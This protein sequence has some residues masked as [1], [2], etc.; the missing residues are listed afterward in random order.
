MVLKLAIL[1]LVLLTYVSPASK[2]YTGELIS[3]GGNPGVSDLTPNISIT[4]NITLYDSSI[5]LVLSAYQRTINTTAKQT[6]IALTA[7][8]NVNSTNRCIAFGFSIRSEYR[9]KNKYIPESG[10]GGCDAFW[11]SECS[12]GVINSLQ[13]FSSGVNDTACGMN[14]IGAPTGILTRCLNASKIFPITSAV[15]ILDNGRFTIAA[16]ASPTD[17]SITYY[18]LQSSP[19]SDGDYDRYVG[20]PYYIT[21]VGR[22]YSNGETDVAIACMLLAPKSENTSTAPTLRSARFITFLSSFIIVYQTLI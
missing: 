18:F 11:S 15:T 20:T 22:P 16:N 13:H 3:L 10:N 8:T 1:Q 17:P 14:V 12:Q 5:N 21:F 9:L 6:I 19:S 2:Q 4:T 7:S